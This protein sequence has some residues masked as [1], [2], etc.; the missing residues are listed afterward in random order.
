ML[1]NRKTAIK[2]RCKHQRTPRVPC[3]CLT[4]RTVVPRL[5]LW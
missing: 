4:E 3:C 1:N 5:L 2:H